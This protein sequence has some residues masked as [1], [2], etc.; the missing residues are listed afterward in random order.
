MKIKVYNKRQELRL[1]SR[2]DANIVSN[3][4]CRITTYVRGL[5]DTAV[6]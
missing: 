5:T 2:K 4:S 1:W 3:G 6:T